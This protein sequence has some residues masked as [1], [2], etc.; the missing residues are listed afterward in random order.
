MMFNTNYRHGFVLLTFLICSWNSS[1]QEA[2]L[3]KQNLN[4]TGQSAHFFA[5]NQRFLVQ[6]AVGQGSV[7]GGGESSRF[8]AFQ[9][10]FSPYP[11]LKMQSAQNSELRLSAFPNPFQ[12][13]I[14]LRFEEAV[15]EAVSMQLRDVNGR[16]VFEKTQI[17]AV[18]M[19]FHLPDHLENGVYF[20]LITS[21]QKSHT[22]TFIKTS[23]P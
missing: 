4:S 18:N 12:N 6:Q 22:S 8:K 14:H 23:A 7:I 13:Q 3:L 9:G 2:Q 11:S 17:P 1:A 5:G 19:S 21:A 15:D 20:L 10:F 16:L